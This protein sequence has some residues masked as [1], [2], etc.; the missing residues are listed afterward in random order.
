VSGLPADWPS[1]LPLPQ[2]TF[3][4]ANGSNGQ[5]AA[6]ILMAA[7]AAEVRR[8]TADFY[9]AV[10]FTAVTD[11]VL[12]RGDRQI[13]LLVENR[14]HSATQTTLVIQVSSR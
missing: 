7:S 10:G 3:I 5:W 4:G 8:P 6:Q 14:D 11:P 1:D 12:N 2:G 9:T 13:T